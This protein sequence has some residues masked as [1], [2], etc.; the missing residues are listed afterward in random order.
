MHQI[1]IIGIYM[2]FSN[3]FFFSPFFSETSEKLWKFVI[4][5]TQKFDFYDNSGDQFYQVRL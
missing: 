2:V 5:L 1:S 3:S 4:L